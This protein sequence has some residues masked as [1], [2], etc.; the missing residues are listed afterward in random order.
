L[1]NEEGVQHNTTTF[2]EHP[3]AITFT[4]NASGTVTAAVA[5]GPAPSVSPAPP[6]AT[7]LPAVPDLGTCEDCGADLEIHCESCNASYCESCEY[8]I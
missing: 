8:G 6:A 1:V 3:M 4:P 5:T 7:P 2:R